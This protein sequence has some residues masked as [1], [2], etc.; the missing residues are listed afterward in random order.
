MKTCKLPQGTKL[1][2]CPHGAGLFATKVFRSGETIG[3]ISG[4]TITTDG[5][6]ASM[7]AITVPV[8]KVPSWWVSSEDEERDW[9]TYLDHSKKPNARIIFDH[10]NLDKPTAPV[11]A[12]KEMKPAEE[13]FI[14]YNEYGDRC[15]KAP[16]YQHTYYHA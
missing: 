5:R 13:I 16:R 7:L 4:G 1:Q 9:S 10:F 14:D 3:V 12:I 8:A 6:K 11:I 2:K 15:Y